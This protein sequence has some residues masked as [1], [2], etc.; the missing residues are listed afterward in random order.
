[1][2]ERERFV[3]REQS[4]VRDSPDRQRTKW[5]RSQMN[6]S[7]LLC[8][9]CGRRGS[10]SASR[11]APRSTRHFCQRHSR[12]LLLLRRPWRD[13]SPELP[14]EPR[15]IRPRPHRAPSSSSPQNHQRY[16]FH[17]TAS[18]VRLPAVRLPPFPVIGTA[19]AAA[20]AGGVYGLK[21]GLLY[22]CPGHP[23]LP[24][25]QASSLRN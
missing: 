20:A 16:G 6:L 7:N 11:R 17:G 19:T 2:R 23:L 1:M 14:A 3:K 18:T 25:F 4:T 9:R 5:P 12:A 15:V 8:F 10:L 24:T 13:R 21:T 22:S